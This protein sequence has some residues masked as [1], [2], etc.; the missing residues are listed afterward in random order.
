MLD[1]YTGFFGTWRGDFFWQ[2]TL[3]GVSFFWSSR[4]LRAPGV[5]FHSD[6]MRALGVVF[7]SDTGVPGAVFNSDTRSL[8][9]VFPSETI[10]KGYFSK[11]SEWESRLNLI[12]C[13]LGCLPWVK[14]YWE[15]PH[16]LCV[17]YLHKKRT[18]NMCR[19]ST[20]F[21]CVLLLMWR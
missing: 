9:A 15:L 14:L 20:T 1:N 13:D 8:G 17:S 5:V 2:G 19:T 10:P 12:K 18:A 6:T 7:Y 21:I 4:N 11:T 16:S 3:R